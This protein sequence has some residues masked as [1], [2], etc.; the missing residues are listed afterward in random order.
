MRKKKRKKETTLKLWYRLTA[1]DSKLVSYSSDLFPKIASRGYHSFPLK[2]KNT[3]M[4]I[5]LCTA[6]NAE[7]K[8][9]PHISYSLKI[10]SYHGYFLKKQRKLN[11]LLLQ[12]ANKKLC[13]FFLCVKNVRDLGMTARSPRAK[14]LTLM[15]LWRLFPGYLLPTVTRLFTKLC[16]PIMPN[17]S[18]Q[19]HWDKK[20][21]DQVQ[22]S[23]LKSTCNVTCNVRRNLLKV[24]NLGPCLHWSRFKPFTTAQLDHQPLNEAAALSWDPSGSCLEYVRGWGY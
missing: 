17:T 7:V 14:D 5:L 18:F 13:I 4:R 10:H 24:W 1:A 6:R 9:T 15:S 2:I 22:V 16:A 19:P 20:D 11:K 3:V 21:S 12:M 8:K 23:V